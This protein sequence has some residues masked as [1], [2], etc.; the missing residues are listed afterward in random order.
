MV[1]D[2]WCLTSLSLGQGLIFISLMLVDEKHLFMS[3]WPFVELW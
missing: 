3:Y 1:S 2:P